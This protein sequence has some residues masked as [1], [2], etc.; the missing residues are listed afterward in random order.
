[1]PVTQ[2][3]SGGPGTQPLRGNASAG[4]GISRTATALIW[5]EVATLAVV[6]PL[7]LAGVTGKGG[8][9]FDP[10]AA[11]IAEAVIAV[12]LAAAAIVA[13]RMP[14]QARPVTAGAVCFAILGFG[15]GLSMTARG[16]SAFDVAYHSVLLPVLIV[17][18]ILLLRPRTGA[19]GAA[20]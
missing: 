15:V 7:H 19:G 9:P 16:G 18:L 12:V 8:P 14:A 1:M 13:W 17:T 5:F 11:G 2:Q 3:S 4:P 10:S 20:G 6:S